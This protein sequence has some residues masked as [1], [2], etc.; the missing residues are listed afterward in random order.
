M[1]KYFSM[2][3]LIFG[4]L[5]FSLYSTLRRS[6][7][8]HVAI[9]TCITTTVVIATSVNKLALILMHP[10]VNEASMKIGSMP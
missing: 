7:I 3:I 4:L 8:S 9:G 10:T 5:G 1:L 6:R 2:V